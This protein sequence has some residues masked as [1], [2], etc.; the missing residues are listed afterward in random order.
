M[1]EAS[2]VRREVLIEFF[3]E[4]PPGLRQ[5]AEA[6]PSSI[7]LF[8]AK[9]FNASEFGLE[10]LVLLAPVISDQIVT[11]VRAHIEAKKDVRIKA[12]GIE[13]AGLSADDAVKVLRELQAGDD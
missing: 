12:D 4:E 2:V 11:I 3:A 1:D 6:H 8:E 10:A 9:G 7:T 5:L 13:L